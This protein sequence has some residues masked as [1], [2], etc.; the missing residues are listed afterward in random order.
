MPDL[1]QTQPKP[2]LRKPNPPG[3]ILPPRK[4]SFFTMTPFTLVFQRAIRLPTGLLMRLSLLL[5]AAS[6]TSRPAS[7]GVISWWVSSAD[8]KQQLAEQP[9]L[10]WRI[11]PVA[12]GQGIEINPVG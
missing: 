3:V 12:N 6:A 11:E 9:S 1:N 2:D 4:T 10:E 7:A 8:L 5:L